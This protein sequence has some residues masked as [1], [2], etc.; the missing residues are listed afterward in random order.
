M[1]KINILTTVL[2]VAAAMLM[3]TNAIGQTHAGTTVPAAGANWTE[4]APTTATGAFTGSSAADAATYLTVGTT[5]PLWAKPDPYFHPNYDPTIAAPVFT[6]TDG[7]TWTW[8]VPAALTYVQATHNVA[9]D[10]NYITLTAPA[11]TTPGDFTVSVEENAPAA[12]GGCSGAT[13]D[14]TVHVVA[15]PSVALASTTAIN[16]CE[17]NVAAFPANINAVIAGGWQN[18]RLAWNLQIATLNNGGT[19]EFYYNSDGSGINATAFNAIDHTTTTFSAVAASGNYDLMANDNLPAFTAF[20][21]GTRAAVTVYTYTLVSIND[22][23]SRNGNFIA[24]NGVSTNPAAFTYYNA[25]AGS[26]TLVITVYPA[27]VTG[28]IYHIS[29]AWAN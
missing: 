25:T 27:P 10:D 1:R 8:T 4:Y 12:F 2:G 21:N 3:S 28:P 7:F 26:T 9:A 19:K 24:L 20:N 13:Q 14:I 5:I 29:S 17:S 16:A 23:A 15:A 6:L 22:Q 11:A 18:Y